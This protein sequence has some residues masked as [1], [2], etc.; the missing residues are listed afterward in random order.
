MIKNKDI[1]TKNKELMRKLL[2][3]SL[4]NNEFEQFVL[5]MPNYCVETRDLNGFVRPN[6][7]YTMQAIYEYHLSKPKFRIDQLLYTTLIH[8]AQEYK[9]EQ[10]IETVLETVKYQLNAEKNNLSPFEMDCRTILN[11][12]RLTIMKN[13]EMY[14]QEKEDYGNVPFWH[15]I[16]E[17]DLELQQKYNHKVL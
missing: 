14:L 3:I 8:I 5:M 16:E 13:K 7:R 1:N 6:R 9:G 12:L 11:E 10:A 17:Y 4:K 2:K 15:N